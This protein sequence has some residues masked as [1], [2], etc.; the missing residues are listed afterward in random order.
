MY[1][2][3]VETGKVHIPPAIL[4][5]L[6]W[7]ILARRRILVGPAYPEVNQVDA[8]GRTAHVEHHVRRLDITVDNSS[9]VSMLED[10]ELRG[11]FSARDVRPRGLTHHLIG[12][13]HDVAQ[14][15]LLSGVHEVRV[16]VFSESLKGEVL[17]VL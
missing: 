11:Y 6:V 10:V 7:T 2:V 13:R 8:C 17:V 16:E 3:T 14:A 1:T 12:N 15:E 4:H 5:G 9:S